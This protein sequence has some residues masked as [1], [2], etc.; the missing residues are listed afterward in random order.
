VN[1]VI[2]PENQVETVVVDAEC[3]AREFGEALLSELERL[4]VLYSEDGYLQ[5]W[6]RFPFPRSRIEDLKGVLD[7]D[8]LAAARRGA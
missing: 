3:P 2:T 1:G 7:A 8:A 5:E 4:L 6:V